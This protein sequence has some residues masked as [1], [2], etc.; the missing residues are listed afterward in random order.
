MLD[1]VFKIKGTLK[2]TAKDKLGQ[3]FHYEE[4]NNTLTKVGIDLICGAIGAP[5]NRPNVISHMAI[6]SGT[7]GGVNATALDDETARVTA[8][9][10]HTGSTSKFTFSA[11]FLSVAAATEYG[12]FNAA[13]NGTMLNTAAFGPITADKLELEAE[14]TIS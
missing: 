3:V 13:N 7:A 2:I 1:N 5:S 12:L 4:L 10:A 9:Y 8:T 14:F 6:G 11:E